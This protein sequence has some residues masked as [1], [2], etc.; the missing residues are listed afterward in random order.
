LNEAL[1]YIIETK[2]TTIPQIVNDQLKFREEPRIEARIGPRMEPKPNAP[3][4]IA[5]MLFLS[6]MVYSSL[7]VSAFSFMMLLRAGTQLL[8]ISAPPIPPI[9]IPIHMR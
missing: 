2:T 6:L 9:R 7:Y 5:L 4:L 1:I 3:V 8:L